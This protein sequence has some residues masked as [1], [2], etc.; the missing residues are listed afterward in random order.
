M[1]S[2]KFGLL[3]AFLLI[4][5]SWFAWQG[6][7]VG[8][9]VTKKNVAIS[10]ILSVDDDMGVSICSGRFAIG[11]L[12]IIDAE[13]KFISVSGKDIRVG[14]DLKDK[15]CFVVGCESA[16]ESVVSFELPPFKLR[17]V[18]CRGRAVVNVVAA[19]SFMIKKNNAPA[20]PGYRCNLLVPDGCMPE[21]EIVRA[22]YYE[23]TSPP[24]LPS[25]GFVS[26][27][28]KKDVKYGEFGLAYKGVFPKQICRLSQLY[29]IRKQCGVGVMI[30]PFQYDAPRGVLR[31]YHNIK[32]RVKH[33][34]KQ[35]IK[36]TTNR[37]YQGFAKNYF[38]N[39]RDLLAQQNYSS[40][41]T[42][43]GDENKSNLLDS[44]EK[45]LIIVHDD[46]SNQIADFVAWKRERGLQVIVK[47]YNDTLYPTTDDL[48]QLIKDSY[49]Q[50][51]ITYVIFIGDSEYIPVKQNYPNPSDTLYSLVSGDDKYHD[52][53]IS[54]IS[55][56]ANDNLPYILQ[57]IIDYE[58]ANSGGDSS[59]YNQVLFVGS[60]DGAD[61]SFLNMVDRE[62]LHNLEK[63]QLEAYNI[64]CPNSNYEI[65]DYTGNYATSDSVINS[66]NT[67][68]SLIYYL[69]HGTETSWLTT[70]LAVADMPR[71]H[72]A[73]QQPFV[74]N[75][76]CSNGK[77]T[78]SGGDCL[79]EA[80]LKAGTP[81][82]PAG[83]IGTISSTTNM[84]WDPPVVML[85]A[86]DEYLTKEQSFVAGNINFTNPGI[87]TSVGGLTFFSV[88]RAMDYCYITPDEGSGA[89]EKIMEQTHLFGD[90][91]LQ[92]R[93]QSPQLLEVC[94]PQTV[95]LANNQ[96]IIRAIKST[97]NQPLAGARVTFYQPQTNYQSTAL[98]NSRG[99]AILPTPVASII[100]TSKPIKLTIYH[101]QAITYQ[102]ELNTS[103]PPIN[104]SIY[105]SS[106]PPTGICNQ[107]YNYTH[108][109]TG[110]TPP[111]QWSITGGSIGTLSLNSNTAT[112][113]GSI[114]TPKTLHYTITVTDANQASTSKQI[115]IL[116]GQSPQFTTQN[117]PIATP[118]NQYTATI[119]TTGTFTPHTLQ[120]TT[121]N[122]PTGLTLNTNT[123]T[124]IPTQSGTYN[125]TITA[126]DT[127]QNTTQQQYTI[128][129]EQ[130]PGLTITNPAQLSTSPVNQAINYQFTASGGA[131]Q[132]YQWQQTAGT[133]PDGITINSQGILTGIPTNPGI[134]NFTIT[135]TDLGT[136]TT[137]DKNFTL[138][139]TSP[140]YLL[141]NQLNNAYLDKT[142]S[143][144]LNY[145]GT[146]TPITFKITPDYNKYYVKQESQTSTFAITGVKQTDWLGDNKEYELNIEFPFSFYGQPY[147]TCK[148][149]TNGYITFANQSPSPNYWA[150]ED[151]L[152][153]SIIIA[154]FWTSMVINATQQT[155]HPEVGIYLSKT[156]NS[157]TVRW[158]GVEYNYTQG[159]VGQNDPPHII[160]TS[161]TIYQNGQI[162]F[163]YGNILSTGRT[164]IGTSNNNGYLNI[165]SHEWNDT[166]PQY[167]QNWTNHP[168]FLL[169]P[170][171]LNW[172]TINNDGIIT[173][174]PSQS[175]KYSF[176][177]TGTDSQN[178]TDSQYQTI[179]VNA[180]PADKNQDGYINNNEILTYIDCWKQSLVTNAELTTAINQWR[181]NNTNN[182]TS[183][184]HQPP[185]TR[186]HTLT[187]TLITPITD[188]LTKIL[189]QRQTIIDYLDQNK[190]IIYA[191][192][193]DLQY[194]NDNNIKYT[195]YHPPQTRSQRSN[196]PN[197]YLTYP[198]ISQILTTYP[199]DY[200]QIC[201]LTS[202]GQSVQGRELWAIKITNQPQQHNNKPEVKIIANIHG[203]EALSGEIAMK[204][205]QHLLQNYQQDQT[206]TQLINTTEIWIIP[207]MN[208]DG[209]QAGTRTNA[210][211]IDLNRSF[212]DTINN[213]LGT[214]YQNQTINTNNLPREVALLTQWSCH[215][216]FVLSASLHTGATL[217][218]YPY[219]N[220][221]AAT[222]TNTPTPDDQLF[223]NIC[224]KYTQTNSD[225]WNNTYN[226]GLLN[227]DTYQ[228]GIINAANWYA[229][230]GEMGDW[231]YNYTGCLE[232][233]IELS[234]T[235]Q[236]NSTLIN[237]YWNDNKTSLINYLKQAQIG[238]HGTV[239]DAQ[240]EEP[241][242][243]K[244]TIQGNNH[245]TYTNPKLG[246]Y[247][248]LLLP[249]TYNLTITANGYT[250]CK[251]TNI[252]VTE[253]QPFNLNIK[254]QKLT[255][256]TITRTF[257]TNNY[258][259]NTNQTITLNLNITGTTTPNAIIINETI[260]DGWTY[261]PNTTHDNN[262]QPLP[263][264]RIHN[265]T[266]S[267]LF[268]DNQVHPQTISY[269]LIAPS[270]TTPATFNGTI[271]TTN[272]TY[273]S[274]TN[275][276]TTNTTYYNITLKQ[277]WNF[278]SIPINLTDSQASTIF[279]KNQ[280]PIWTWN[281]KSYHTVEQLYPNHGYITY[282]TKTKTIK[283]SG[284]AVTNN[285]CQLNSGWNLI[286]TTTN[287]QQTNN[288][289]TFWQWQN[290]IF[291]T[292][293]ELKILKSYWLH[294]VNPITINL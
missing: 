61:Q 48:A 58:K 218:C 10:S 152:K 260:P 245:P 122:L 136:N 157:L 277:G 54:R 293:T 34:S 84:D 232:T 63:P 17:Q 32:F 171:P 203:D 164:Q 282:S 139:I 40:F 158:C 82:N 280:F 39:Y 127:I 159:T 87:T 69:G 219:G 119:T 11:E 275:T 45:L 270:T 4:L 1:F 290:N 60:N 198:E 20:L 36:L 165:F 14:D 90:C 73:K 111:Y 74:V 133:L 228:H 154:P 250:P 226:S 294:L 137:T 205:I 121:G 132:G 172:L 291:Q 41:N 50:Q 252:P 191:N 85:Q 19:N 235:K 5:L 160:N 267:W 289:L 51:D 47:N 202:I 195:K 49:E 212:P 31:I 151:S 257:Q 75:A 215:H 149:G 26:R 220:N 253:N 43:R 188:N 177:I 167:I 29:H 279:G 204:L 64:V 258:T 140:F 52:L 46:F 155:L 104:L 114:S 216:N 62:I 248:R 105:S 242:Y 181:Q 6:M 115:T 264:P 153:T 272:N 249:G 59:W 263:E 190:I 278:F 76:N 92:L 147:A 134:Y 142:Y 256:C 211:G 237:Q 276:I 286:G 209:L 128:T 107:P 175:G 288:Q 35:K 241:I 94:H 88:N 233:T 30:I 162:K 176:T 99:E 259:P 283:I 229:V 206:I 97:T 243:A 269:Q 68:C 7:D 217:I 262:N 247:H 86:F 125:F 79:A 65:Y 130:L 208:P 210:N 53:F 261:I 186:N 268:Y 96:I 2:R 108:L 170:K 239:T 150:N 166:N 193:N 109:A 187:P 44:L 100:D 12:D 281:G 83:C 173:G 67:G 116:F 66:W 55:V 144:Q 183:R 244:I 273:P 146:N 174:T 106:T 185:P 194:L 129:V 207:Y 91:T 135:L 120:V 234:N 72:N 102:T 284:T 246:D 231:C 168:D 141:Y 77:F 117:L 287:S 266:L 201:Q 93:T 230:T 292:T 22:E 23:V 3:L 255:N 285:T 13:D 37:E 15:N 236:P 148:V 199:K 145:K 103:S 124:G 156:N 178:N 180:P 21:L 28:N 110:G 179:T 78:R 25:A 89:A 182:R 18:S 214:Y 143:Q 112:L 9:D 254:L 196:P 200:P 161:L 33:R 118:N 126:T 271:T 213:N 27:G 225:M 80:M 240:T 113:T 223:Q 265:Q 221:T 70:D 189:Q 16:G 222:N 238:I 123:I 101:P 42:T 131:N 169:I 57:K 192:Q 138:T 71:L 163:S 38:S 224:L 197:G 251:R 56:N 24:P 95:N 98:T 274:Q 184:N 8:D 227:Y 81:T